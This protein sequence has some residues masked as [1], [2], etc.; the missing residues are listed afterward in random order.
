MRYRRRSTTLQEILKLDPKRDNEQISFLSASYD[1]PWDTQRALELALIR[2]FAVP[3]SSKL[4]VATREFTERTQKR[5]DDTVAIISAIGFH[6][7]SSR[8]G[9][10]AIKRMNQIHGHYSIPNDEFVY[11]LSTFV[12]EPLRWNTR[13]GWRPHSEHERQATYYFWAEVGKY[14]NI[15]GIPDSLDALD[16]FNRD[17]EQAHFAYHPNNRILADATEE[18]FL[19]WFLPVNAS[20]T[21]GLQTFGRDAVHCLMD[22]PML[23]AFG[24]DPPPAWLKR[25]IARSLDLRRKLVRVLPARQ[26]PYTLPPLRSYPDGYSLEQLGPDLSEPDAQPPHLG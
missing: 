9:R 3:N 10:R 4:M 23:A 26:S 14:M 19:S 22:G 17:Y 25:T 24:Y 16:A 6:G 5:Y 20:W 7:Y 11:V 8:V 21:C 1:F 18:L 15:T 13:Y 2:T 12:L